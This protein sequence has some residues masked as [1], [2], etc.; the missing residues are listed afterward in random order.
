LALDAKESFW[1]EKGNRRGRLEPLVAASV[2]P[3]GAFLADGSE[4]TGDYGI[5]DLDLYEFHRGR[6]EVLAG[7]GADL[8]AC[9]TL[10]G[11]REAE[12]LLRL[13]EE[14]PG[15]W[16]WISFSC[17]DGRHLSDGGLLREAA[18]VCDAGIGVAAVGI[19]CTAP[20]HIGSL[21][22]EARK[23]TDKPILVYPNSGERYDAG[24]KTWH[25][26]LPSCPWEDIGM[27]WVRRGASGIGGCCRVGP[28]EIRRIRRA[29][30]GRP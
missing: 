22:E 3:Y 11:Q 6:W 4:Y 16:A 24:R 14:T 28:D 30:L 25:S 10:P 19:N 27:E 15:Q 2:G 1:R 9:E 13:V 17:K 8:M 23:G 20:E 29:V 7:K 5:S 18:R 12:V 26:S 21:V